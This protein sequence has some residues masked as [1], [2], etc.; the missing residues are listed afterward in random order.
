MYDIT[1][2]EIDE[3]VHY[4]SL[5]IDAYSRKIMGHEVSNDIRAESVVK[6][7]CRTARQRSTCH[8]LIHH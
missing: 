8:F 5:V 1:Y 6:A 2:V 3:G 4:L 7:L